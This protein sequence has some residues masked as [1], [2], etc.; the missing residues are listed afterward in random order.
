MA[1]SIY[2]NI[3]EPE[4]GEMPRLGDVLRKAK[5]STKTGMGNRKFTLLGDP[6]LRLNYPKH[7]IITTKV[8][9]TPVVSG[10]TDTF[11]ALQKV[12]VSGLVHNQQNQ[13]MTDFNGILFPTIFDKPQAIET[14]VNDPGSNKRT[15][16]LQN[17]ILFRGKVSVNNGS[18][19]FN[20][21]VPKDINYQFG[22]GKI[23][24]YAH[25]ENIDAAGA[26]QNIIIGGM[27][28]DPREDNQGPEVD[29]Y[30][31]NEEFVYG[32][33][34]DENPTLLVKLKDESGINTTGNGIGHDITAELDEEKKNRIVLNEFYEADLDSY[35]SGEAR[36]PLSEL[37]E[38]RHQVKVKAWDVYN[39]SGQGY[40]EFVVASS[41][42]LALDH[43][44]NYPNPFTTNTEF[45]FDHNRPGDVLNVRIQIF[46]VSGKLVKTI[47]TQVMS[48][49]YRVTGINWNGRDDFGDKI[50]RGVYIYQLTVRGSNNE[51]AN[52]FQKL[53]ILR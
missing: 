6:A 51:V 19:Q 1:R 30:M 50:G 45:Q 46:T 17:T 20:F 21:I 4:N 32:G 14:L 52:K 8:N 40:T 41:E 33:M 28:D 3:F 25:N 24:Y 5:N 22:K 15:F 23:S 38:G 53:V 16:K 35:Q 10:D 31:N 18:F 27:A 47:Y 13:K 49:G 48:E 44:L 29:I 36:Y 37:E 43:V 11:K 12:S 34:T 7:N 2:D 9:S 26:F 42:E 39:N